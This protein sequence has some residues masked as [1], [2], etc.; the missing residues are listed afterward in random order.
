VFLIFLA[1]FSRRWICGVLG[2]VFGMHTMLTDSAEGATLGVTPSAISNNYSGVL[3]LQ[4]GGLANGEQVIVRRYLDFNSNGVVEA[5]EP[6]TDTFRIS[7]GGV[8]TIGGVTNLNVP[9]D[10]N[11]SAGAITSTLSFGLQLENFVGQ[12]IFSLVSPSGN[13]PPQTSLLVVTNTA[14]A[15]SVSGT[16]FSGG[17]PVPNA[18]VVALSQPNNN[19]I[20]AI[21]A[22]NAG[23]YLYK[24]KPGA[25]A[26]LP[27]LPN[28][29]TDQ[30]IAALVTLTNGGS[31]TANLFLTNG[32]I[33]NT[34]SGQVTDATNGSPLGGAFLQFESGSLFS[35]AFTDTNG[36]YAAALS[37]S[38]WRARPEAERLA[39]RAY[40]GPQNRLQVNLTAGS[41][42]NLNF[43][44][45]KADALF[46][47]RITDSF[48]VPFA[49]VRFFGND[50]SDQF[51]ANG[52]S[53]AN[54]N[55]ATAILAGSGQWNVSPSPDD[56]AA[57]AG[58]IVSSG[59]GNTT[60]FPGQAVSQDF[61]VLRATAQI[62]GHLQDDLGNPVIGVSVYANANI[63][64]INYNTSVDTDNS[65]NYLLPA[66]GGN[67]SLSVNNCC[68][69]SSLGSHGLYDPAS[70]HPVTIPPTNAVLNIT[71][72]PTGTP[73]ITQPTRTAPGQFSFNLNGSVGAGY[74]IQASTNLSTSNWFYLFS[75][76]LTSSPMF[77]QDNQ[78]TNK[79]R[80]YRVQKN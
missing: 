20:G 58:Y 1:V 41:V 71:V 65:G 14:P 46:Y 18:I 75:L 40:V 4:I 59:L 79:L 28:Y 77:L 73:F 66:A 68:G 13:F 11:P 52:I 3:T 78:A 8:S 43:A 51:R 19:Y 63:A 64:G 29:Y 38:F 70:S 22:N 36:N 25:Y 2:V 49:N 42:S 24:L 55:Y 45:P 31:A 53:D 48:S 32:S 26:L 23:Q 62:S 72:Y 12:Q 61:V 16:V 34:L 60:L 50:D 67:W 10:S 54:G 76:S 6:L 57:L 7:D 35:V 44:V 5:S 56:N 17:S 37:P 74:T 39:R 15:Q 21:I 33:A 9:Y 27:V 80:F 30:S 69:D 47:G